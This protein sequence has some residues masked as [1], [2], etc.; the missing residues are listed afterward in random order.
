MEKIRKLTSNL[1]QIKNDLLNV[2][3]DKLTSHKSY[4]HWILESRKYILPQKST[5]E[6]NSI[7]YDIQCKPQDYFKSMIYIS[8]FIENEH[9]F[10]NNVKRTFNKKEEQMK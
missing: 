7:Y 8:R 9:D 10:V 5:F 4:H 6:K 3:N 2:E 1:R